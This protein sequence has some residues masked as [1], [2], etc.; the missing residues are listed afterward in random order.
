MNTPNTNTPQ[1]NTPAKSSANI[2]S[3]NSD[4]KLGVRMEERPV[5]SVSQRSQVPKLVGPASSIIQEDPWDLDM[6]LARRN[7][8]ATYPYLSTQTAHEVIGSL[9]VPEDLITNGL[10]SAP[11]QNFI[12]WR[13]QI[14]MEFQMTGIPQSQGCVAIVWI[15]LS[16][17]STVTQIVNNFSALS[18]NQVCYLFP[19]ANTVGRMTIPFNSPQGYLNIEKTFPEDFTNT[20]GHLVYVVFNQLQLGATA[21]DTVSVSTF[22]R[23]ENNQFKVPR[24]SAVSRIRARP[25]ADVEAHK[26]DTSIIDKI[27][28][29]IMPE[30][31]VGDVIDGAAAIFGL[32]K[33]VD[34]RFSEPSKVVSTQPMNFSSGPE[35]IDV[36]NF[37]PS[38]IATTD[39]DTFATTNDEMAMSSLKTIYSYL[40]SFVFSNT[41]QVG[42]VIASFPANPMPNRLTV[43]TTSQIPL[44]SYL[45]APYRFWTGSL[46][47]NVQ[48]VS[49]SFQTGKLLFSINY[50]EYAPA[51]GLP[52]VSNASQYALV[53]EINQGSNQVEFTVPYI[54][55]TPKLNVPNTSIPS[56]VN[57]L[58]MVNISVLNPLI[59]Q[60]GTPD[61]ITLNIFIAGGEDFKVDTLSLSN[62]IIPD[63]S[64]VPAP[65]PRKRIKYVEIQEESESDIEVIEIPHKPRVRARPQAS[66]QPLITP[67]S[68]VDLASTNA[69][70]PNESIHKRS[71]DN[72]AALPSIKDVLRKYQMAKSYTLPAP[73]PTQIGTVLTIPI[74]DFFGSYP[75]LFNQAITTPRPP[76]TGLFNWYSMM[77]RQFKGGL[78]FKIMFDYMVGIEYPFSIFYSPPV[79]NADAQTVANLNNTIANNLYLTDTTTADYNQRSSYSAFPLLTRLPINY[80]NGIVKTAEFNVPYS[81]RFFSIISKLG[82]ATEN[83][84]EFQEVCSLGYIHILYTET[85]FGVPADLRLNMF[86]SLADDARFGTLFNVPRVATIGMNNS[87]GTFVSNSFPDDYDAQNPIVNTLTII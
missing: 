71:E 52:I 28:D 74:T 49:T 61:E 50:D 81:N 69:I 31:I 80:V 60:N 37:I 29:S 9:R 64:S 23:F 30:D 84:L 77:Y 75:I 1:N 83:Y 18:V 46:N 25:Q 7:F 16:E 76:S 4:N 56:D 5:T 41:Q 12:Y 3:F 47:Y 15:P 10:T 48:I 43:N 44:L 62:Q 24:R 20:L 34:P 45:T 26:P 39:Q 38:S 13:G 73:N 57:S 79:P 42:E 40:G 33:P 87:T 54:A 55:P 85:R 68:N 11:F 17:Q 86:L 6:M 36:M 65:I 70:S 67:M 58:G 66:A 72:Q 59:N 19:N 53:V 14:E 27:V 22:S 35:R 51:V 63:N 8:I 78:N 82:P 2:T 21:S 32:D